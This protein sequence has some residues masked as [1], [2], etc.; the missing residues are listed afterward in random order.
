MTKKD[1]CISDL[2]A[3]VLALELAPGAALDEV[4][5][6]ESYGLSRTPLREVL[7][8]LAGE[9][10]ISLEANRGAVVSAMDIAAMRQFFQTAPIIYCAISRLAAENASLAQLAKLKA[11]QFGFTQAKAVLDAPAMALANHHF[12]E[13]I[14]AMS[15]NPYLLPAMGRLLIDHTRISQRFYNAS[16][17][18]DGVRIT[19]AAHQHDLLID[20]IERRSPEKA[21]EITLDHWALSRDEIERYV[22]P[23]PLPDDTTRRTTG[24]ST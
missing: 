6:S 16:A 8:R 1:A 11:E 4:S 23:D 7:Q 14:G 15:G 13:T 20:A 2:K 24:E 12:H 19:Q 17:P 21:V 3:R 9:G 18:H 10:Y 22:W 5:L